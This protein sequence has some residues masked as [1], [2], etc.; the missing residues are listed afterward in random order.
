MYRVG[1]QVF[2]AD[3]CG[4][5]ARQAL[6]AANEKPQ[7]ERVVLTVDSGASDT[8]IP[9]SVACNIPLVNT[10]KTG[11]EYEVANG[12]VVTNLGERQAKVRI[13]KESSKHLLMNFQVVEINKP[14]LAVSRIVDAGHKVMF[15]K[16]DPHIALTSC[17]KILMVCNG[18]TCEIEVWIENPAGPGY[19]PSTPIFGRQRY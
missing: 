10:L 1:D 15:T 12:G 9:P 6:C 3:L 5:W 13:G 8:V 4:L 16:D 7:W 14:L 11:I 19:K 2:P 18:G 17:E